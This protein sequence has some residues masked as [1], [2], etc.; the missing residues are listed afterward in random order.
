MSTPFEER[1]RS[2]M[3]RLEV[4]PR[5]G[6]AREAHRRRRGRRR[7]A[8]AAVGTAA[9]AT[10]AAL[11]A[12]SV[13]A[14]P[15]PTAVSAET[16]AYVLSHVSAALAATNAVSYASEQETA[17]GAAEPPDITWWQYGGRLRQLHTTVG[18]APVEDVGYTVSGGH[19]S[20]IDVHY[21]SRTWDLLPLPSNSL[22]SQ[23]SQIQGC[24]PRP[25]FITPFGSAAGWAS[26][27]ET[28]LRCG[29]FTVAGH[30]RTGGTGM[31]V[32]TGHFLAPTTLLVDPR[33]YLPVELI[34]DPGIWVDGT[35]GKIVPVKEDRAEF[36][37]LP[38][39]RSNLA[40][41]SPPIPPGFRK[42]SG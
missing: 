10:G 27:I 1:L 25:A 36:R 17:P 19:V 33:T 23:P 6:L 26:A 21:T 40:L 20:E 12:A 3:A 37:W 4:H 14:T 42:V 32:L 9:A 11:A 8:A 29:L 5:P 18:G 28:G 31:I 38:P 35:N 7:A 2:E 24:T 22:P 41:L 30:Q 15:A 13:T 39:T 16:T 34:T